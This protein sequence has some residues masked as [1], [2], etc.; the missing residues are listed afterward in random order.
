M[1]LFGMSVCKVSAAMNTLLSL[2]STQCFQHFCWVSMGISLTT[3]HWFPMKP[4]SMRVMYLNLPVPC[5][6]CISA[7]GHNTS[8]SN[9][10]KCSVSWQCKDLEIYQLRVFSSCS[11]RLS[12]GIDCGQARRINIFRVREAL[13]IRRTETSVGYLYAF[14]SHGKWFNRCPSIVDTLAALL[15]IAKSAKEMYKGFTNQH[16]K[17]MI[18]HCC[19]NNQT[20]YFQTQ[21]FTCVHARQHDIFSGPKHSPLLMET[22]V[23]FGKCLCRHQTTGH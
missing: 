17:K 19:K 10:C 9:H 23:C 20:V 8:P 5:Y 15:P 1:S 22:P 11:Y 18:L 3:S 4:L 2:S 16:A 12:W 14:E 21:L 7:A 6:S 13:S